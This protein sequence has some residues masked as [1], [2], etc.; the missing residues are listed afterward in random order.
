MSVVAVIGGGGRESVLLEKYSQSSKVT[1][2]LAIPGN[3]LMQSLTVKEVATFP[4]IKT[5][6]KNKILKICLTHKVSL[7]DVS[8]DD[9][10][11]A[12]VSDILR[13]N[14][15]KVIGPS[16]KAGK[17]EWSKSF[18]RRLLERAGVA[19]PEFYIFKSQNEGIKF[20]NN[21]KD[22]PWFVKADGLAS[23]KGA[24][25]AKNNIEA[26]DKI[27]SL[28]QF[29]KSGEKFLIEKWIKSDGQVAEEFSAF[30]ISDGKSFKILGFAQ[31]HKRANDGDRGENTGG[32]GASFPPKVI[33][34]NI[35]NQV[36]DIFKKTFSVLNKQKTPY[37]GVL[38]LGGILI[39]KKV[40]VI[41]FNSRWGDPE[42][43]VIVPSILNDFYDLNLAVST[44]KLANIILKTKK[45]SRVSVAV[46]PFGYPTSKKHIGDEIKGFSKFLNDENAKIYGAGLN[47]KNKKYF[48]T[49]GR[50]FHVVS[51]GKNIK[52]ARKKAYSLIGKILKEGNKLHFRSDIGWRDLKRI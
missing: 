5:T 8:Q 29:G 50:T 30:A 10:V 51:E 35:E 16:K 52:D 6:D 49:G 37:V 28:K 1:K 22:Q 48:S 31:D 44:G 43:Q 26:I 23:G 20:I 41:E 33:D 47:I 34:K 40:Y 2:L 11:A 24:M 32:M 14:G 38:F 27:K 9:A 4:N 3:D 42:A 7:V 36:S 13:K 17:I 19:Q 21:Q 46:A 15:I 39:G 18:S 12:G 25:A 45:L